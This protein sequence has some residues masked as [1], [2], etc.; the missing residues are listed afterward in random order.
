MRSTSLPVGKGCGQD[1]DAATPCP[2][3]GRQNHQAAS[4]GTV[5]P[6]YNSAEHGEWRARVL[7][8]AGH[9]CQWVENGQRCPKDAPHHRLF[10][11]HIRELRDGG[12]PTDPANGQ[13]LCGAHHTRKTMKARATR[14]A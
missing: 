10:A 11:D 14:F 12:H 8:N 5:D 6:H 7:H 3:V 4:E 1:H 13:C 2:E 9:R